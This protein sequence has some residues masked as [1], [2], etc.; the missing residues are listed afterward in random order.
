[1]A[2]Q[3]P[4]NNE[5]YLNKDFQ[6]IYPELLD[7]VQKLTY[8]WNP[9]VS[10]ESDPAVLLLKLNA[11]IADKLNY[12]LDKNILE[13]FPE[14]VSQYRNAY[15]MFKQ[16]G[17]NMRW[18]RAATGKLSF[19]WVSS[20]DDTGTLTIPKYT[21]FTNVDGDNVVTLIR[22]AVVNKDGSV[23]Y[24]EED[25]VCQGTPVTY[26]INKHTNIAITDLDTQNRLYFI[27]N[28]VAENFI[29]ITNTDSYDAKTW[30]KVENIY[31]HTLGEK[32]FGFGID[33]YTNNCY[34]Q[35]PDDIDNLIGNGLT[36]H[37]IKTSGIN[38]NASANTITKLYQDVTLSSTS[39][40]SD[41]TQ[42]TVTVDTKNLGIT[43][44]SS[45]TGG[46]NP[47]SV[48][49]AYKHYQKQVGVF[50][51]LVTI[52]DYINAIINSG[53]VSNCIVADRHTDIQTSYKIMT[54]QDNKDVVK[55]YAD[56]VLS[57]NILE[58]GLGLD[59]SNIELLKNFLQVSA[60]YTGSFN[61]RII[62][63][64]AERDNKYI[65]TLEVTRDGQT[66]QQTSDSLT[67]KASKISDL[68]NINGLLTTYRISVTNIPTT[69]AIESVVKFEVNSPLDAF[70]LKLTLLNQVSSQITNLLQYTNTF[71]ISALAPDEAVLAYVDETK[72]INHDFKDLTEGKICYFKNLYPIDVTIIPVNSLTALQ[73]QQVQDNVRTALLNKFQANKMTFG[74]APSYDEIYDTILYCDERIKA[75]AL[76]RLSYA[77]FVVYSDK[78]L[79]HDYLTG[80]DYTY[81]LATSI[82]KPTIADSSYTQ[83]V[84]GY[85]Q[86]KDIENVFYK[87]I[88]IGNSTVTISATDTTVLVSDIYKFI[89]VVNSTPHI[90]NNNAVTITNITGIKD[91]ENLTGK[92]TLTTGTEIT[93]TLSEMG[94]ET[95]LIQQSGFAFY[96]GEP[97]DFDGISESTLAY[98]LVTHT[99]TSMEILTSDDYTATDIITPTKGIEIE[100]DN[101]KVKNVSSVTV[102]KYTF[103]DPPTITVPIFYESSVVPTQ[104]A[105]KQIEIDDSDKYYLNGYYNPADGSFYRDYSVAGKIYLNKIDPMKEKA[106]Y[107]KDI[108]PTDSG[109]ANNNIY[110]YNQYRSNWQ[111]DQYSDRYNEITNDIQAKSI[112]A[113][114]TPTFDTD[115]D[116]TFQV[117]Q[118]RWQGIQELVGNAIIDNVNYI[119]TNTNIDFNGL[120][121]EITYSPL[122]SET[123]TGDGSKKQFAL[124]STINVIYRVTIDGEVA[125]SDTYAFDSNS[126]ILTF[127]TAPKNNTKIT[128]YYDYIITPYG[129][130]YTLKDNESLVFYAPNLISDTEY[131]QYV[132]YELVLADKKSIDPNTTYRLGAGEYICFFY[133][134]STTNEND[135]TVYQRVYAKYP[136]NTIFTTSNELTASTNQI[137]R[138]LPYGTGLYQNTTRTASGD[139]S[140]GYDGNWLNLP[141]LSDSDT[142]TIKKQ[143][144]VT[145]PNGS[146]S[147][148]CYWTRSRSYVENNERVYK[149]FE[150]Y[151]KAYKVDYSISPSLDTGK[152]V[153]VQIDYDRLAQIDLDKWTALTPYTY[154]LVFNG[155]EWVNNGEIHYTADKLPLACGISIN[156][157]TEAIPTG[158]TLTIYKGT[159]EYILR[160]GEYFIYTDNTTQGL[161]ILGEGTNLTWNTPNEN[162]VWQVPVISYDSIVEQGLNAFSETDWYRLNNTDRQI[163]ATEQQ[164]IS[165]GA[166]DI[167]QISPN[168]TL[169]GNFNIQFS[170]A[171]Q[172]VITQDTSTTGLFYDG[173]FATNITPSTLA[174]GTIHTLTDDEYFVTYENLDD[175][176]NTSITKYGKG[177]KIQLQST[178]QK[179]LTNSVNV[180]YTFTGLVRQ[181]IILPQNFVQVTSVKFNEATMSTSDFEYTLD[182]ATNIPNIVGGT[183]SF[184]GGS[185]GEGTLVVTGYSIGTVKDTDALGRYNPDNAQIGTVTAE[186][187]YYTRYT[188]NL[189]YS[190][191]SVVLNAG[192]VVRATLSLNDFT[193]AYNSAKNNDRGI[194]PVY[195]NTLPRHGYSVLDIR[196]G[197]ENVLTIG[198][199]QSIAFS[200][201]TTNQTLNTI[202]LK[203]LFRAPLFNYTMNATSSDYI[204]TE[205][206]RD[207]DV[208]TIDS[209]G[210]QKYPKVWVFTSDTWND[211]A[212]WTPVDH[213]VTVSY[214]EKTYPV[215]RYSP[216]VYLPENDYV[217]IVKTTPQNFIKPITISLQKLQG[218]VAPTVAITN[219]YTIRNDSTIAAWVGRITASTYFEFTLTSHDEYVESSVTFT[220]S[221]EKENVFVNNGNEVTVDELKT[222]GISSTNDWATD[223][224]ITTKTTTAPVVDTVATIELL[225]TNTTAQLDG[226]TNYYYYRIHTTNNIF[227]S[228]EHSWRSV[229]L[230]VDGLESVSKI[231]NPYLTIYP[232]KTPTNWSKLTNG[233]LLERIQELNIDNNFNFAYEVPESDLIANPLDSK[234]FFNP[235]HIYNKYTIPQI[236]NITAEISTR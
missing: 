236:A 6:T 117:N 213:T 73:Q 151:N 94:I 216:D 110:T 11:I 50:D 72:S 150:N 3:N 153:C 199:N 178:S 51:T 223:F 28:D 131:S 122:Y 211:S 214:D 176:I 87:N 225:Q 159:N 129:A 168:N 31:N 61:C 42:T 232:L 21:M 68:S 188:P 203:S 154:T 4:L 30:T 212:N 48:D 39:A 80:D 70:D 74:E 101:E 18:Y 12:N 116:I 78:V 193:I 9:S 1:M 197:N 45:I 58:N 76:D 177:T 69:G 217:M 82:Y 208:S 175:N 235:N 127:T 86:K 115:S 140:R 15:Q 109:I 184:K 158:S 46:E 98:V 194:I 81:D 163:T 192:E 20:D 137:A 123:F 56:P 19:K 152:T 99:N 221:K 187:G 66:V 229:M 96:H 41:V 146:S 47:E 174:D 93:K 207:I 204:Y 71:D 38:G 108:T 185:L 92:I 226:N 205:G 147:Y 160:S 54:T 173:F 88:N 169:Q 166:G 23:Y 32:I 83:I 124:S 130:E 10:N 25:N 161:V 179:S 220:K 136:P 148:R 195:D 120:H 209:N 13:C 65:Y 55:Y 165:L 7:L 218:N 162:T 135:E 107:Y 200:Y 156:L 128:A 138:G 155:T 14:T 228:V 134:E 215:T 57:A 105:F 118:Q 60:I 102:Y 111:F 227:N 16:L 62:L 133:T 181:S 167:V 106:V 182:Y 49:D 234:A 189:G 75:I 139:I 180:T 149:L 8:K 145:L 233:K 17:Y 85:L 125:E 157:W 34:I 27:D 121:N 141:Q 53:L 210:T 143:N 52:R 37:Y 36:I 191:L 186:Y 95:S 100:I 5:N 89:G 103:T 164:F 40:E 202:L 119:T 114:V 230:C 170:N 142:V 22:E 132:Y 77:T 29:E 24:P 222:L 64:L 67:T 190:G 79:Y 224:T 90:V 183:L 43:N 219:G 2:I 201:W 59:I 91:T 126:H 26:T 104:L 198:K 172:E 97:L 112:L 35:F 144:I 231:T 44:T 33:T 63:S 171:Q 84:N 196:M 113:G 206:G